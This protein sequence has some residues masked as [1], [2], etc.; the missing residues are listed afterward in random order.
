MKKKLLL[1]APHIDDIEFS[2]AG[3]VVKLI[4]HGYEPIYVSFSRCEKSVPKELDKKIMEVELNKSLQILGIKNN[5]KFNFPVR[6]FPKFRQDILEELVKIKKNINPDI[7]FL[8]SSYDVHQDHKT[9]NEEGKRAFKYC[10]IL[11]YESFWNNYAFSP[12]YYS[13]LETRHL[14]LKEKASMQ[15]KSQ[16]IRKGI[17]PRMIWEIAS[18][19]GMQINKKYAEAFE[20]IRIIDILETGDKL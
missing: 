18:V 13:S 16:Q 10:T 5:I 14:E 12:N 17:D 20:A 9:I 6:E 4:E 2:C 8:P 15:Y 11:G 7:I 3:T 1:L 19:R